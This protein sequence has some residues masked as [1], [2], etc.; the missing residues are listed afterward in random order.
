MWYSSSQDLGSRLWRWGLAPLSG[1]YR[2]GLSIRRPKRTQL[3]ACPVISVGNL[4]VGGAGKTPLTMELVRRLQEMGQRVVVV[5]RGYRRRSHGCLV[6]PEAEEHEFLW[7]AR[8]GDEPVMMALRS[9]PARVVVAK[10]RVEAAQK[11]MDLFSPHVIVADDAYQHLRLGRDLNVLAIHA[12]RGFG[13][14]CLLP[15]GPLRE[16]L[17]A[18]E[19]ADLVVFT[20]CDSSLTAEELKRNHGVPQD[21]RA[22]RCGFEPAA[23]VSGPGLS[24]FKGSLPK[25]VVAACGIA[26]PAGFFNSVEKTG[27]EIVRRIEYG[28]HRA[29][30]AGHLGHALAQSSAEAVVVTEKDQVR[31]GKLPDGLPVFAL[32]IEARLDLEGKKLLENLLLRILGP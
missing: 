14:R 17:R 3:I 15:A 7:A 20:H 25:K 27:M 24:E 30:D 9:K 19:R 18:L 31:L 5:S 21:I 23:L 29:L 16:P 26:H 10:D 22:F 1:L 6:L 11:A 13:N 28:D 8:Y 2:L 32:R 4:T 12:K